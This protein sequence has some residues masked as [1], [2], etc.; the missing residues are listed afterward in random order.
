MS[1]DL[2]DTYELTHSD[3]A[4]FLGER[5]QP[6]YRA[7]QVFRWVHRKPAA[8]FDEM[9]DLP[10]ALR[11]ELK[12]AFAL[13]PFA[14]VARS[15]AEDSAKLLV[16]LADGEA[17]ECVRMET[18]EG[19]ASL[20]LSSQV[21]CAIRCAFCASGAGGFV[22]H[23]TAGEM[24][25]QA[26]TLRL[27]VGPA[28]NV[29]FMGMGEPMQN[30][31]AVMRAIAILTDKHG[32]GLSPERVTVATSGA[33]GGI[34]RYARE[35]QATELAVSLN[36]PDDGLRQ[37]LMPGAR[38]AL[39]DVLTACDE[40]TARH[41]G[42]PV[43]YTYV[44]LEGVNDQPAQARGLASLL[45]GRRHHVNLI[46]YNAVE[47]A[48]FVRPSGTEMAA[49]MRRLQDAGLNVSLRHSKGGAINAACGQ[50]RA[51]RAADAQPPGFTQP[52][53]AGR[54]GHP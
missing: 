1:A 2:L 53:S 6:R 14:V 9:T 52:S 23:L 36:A 34:S 7:D 26:V 49:F 46:P 28:R 38:D 44:L 32:W 17:V 45:S 15:E 29:V 10:A 50:L 48:R 39:Q 31:E 24:V 19:A 47:G 33:A 18:G 27:L 54:G 13:G 20:C 8:S 22:R 5:G 11:E 21:G 51:S 37:Q 3:L 12:G 25:R 35:G 40:F 42:R 30:V 41:R 16:A 4:A 43:T